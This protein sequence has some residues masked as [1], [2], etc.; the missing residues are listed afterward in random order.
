MLGSALLT[1][2]YVCEFLHYVTC[3]L[4]VELSAIQTYIIVFVCGQVDIP[5][6]YLSFF[7]EDDDELNSIKEVS[8]LSFYF[9]LK[10]KCV[11]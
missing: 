3:G 2:R 8:E 4:L 5:V 9:V 11:I 7:L 1:F 6:K 10:L